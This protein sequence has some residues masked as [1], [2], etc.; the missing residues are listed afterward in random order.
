MIVPRLF[1]GRVSST[2]ALLLGWC[3]ATV[4]QPVLSQEVQIIVSSDEGDRLT[5]KPPARFQAAARPQGQSQSTTFEIRDGVRYQTMDGFGASFLEAG[6][7]CINDLPPAEQEE[8]LRA[9]FDPK[10][11]AGFSAM[12]TVLASTDFMSAGPFY[13]YDPTPGDVD[14]KD[15]SF[16]YC[17]PSPR[18]AKL[19]RW[20]LTAHGLKVYLW[21]SQRRSRA[22]G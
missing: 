3:A 16:L 14:M 1:R 19:K 11:G 2:L 17:S 9:L 12:K 10:S 18:R 7:I 6:L 13:S 15:S 4:P 5:A 22:T 20:D 21:M 8:V